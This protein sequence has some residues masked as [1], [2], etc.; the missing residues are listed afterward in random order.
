MQSQISSDYALNKVIINPRYP[1]ELFGPD[2]LGNLTEYISEKHPVVMSVLAGACADYTDGIFT[3]TLQNNGIETLSEIGFAKIASRIIKE[4][5][6]T[7]VKVEIKVQSETFEE[8][9]RKKEEKV[10]KI[11]STKT[12]KPK[13]ENPVVFG[14]E[15]KSGNFDKISRINE[16]S[17]NV[18]LQGELFKKDIDARETRN[19]KYIVTFDITDYEGSI[20]CKLFGIEKKDYLRLFERLKKGVNVAVRGEAQY[21]KY[22]RE[23]LVLA[24]DINIVSKKTRCDNAPKKRVELHLHTKMSF[25]DAMS[26]VTEIVKKAQEWGHKAIAIT[27]HG[28]VQAFPDSVK[29]IGDDFKVIFG[30]EAYLIDLGRPIA[31]N[32]NGQS[33][34]DNVVIFDIETT[35]FSPEKDRI[36]E[37]G[38]VKIKNGQIADRFSSFVNP[39]M[40]ISDKISRLTGITDDMVSGAPVIE[41]VLEQFVDFCGDAVLVAHNAAFDMGFI[42]AN[43]K[44]QGMDFSPAYIDTVE[45]ARGAL[46]E[47]ESH[48]LNVV[49]QALGV[50]LQGHHRAVNDAEATAQIYLK[51]AGLAKVKSV[52]ELNEAFEK[53][54]SFKEKKYYHA[55]IIAKNKKGLKNL[56]KIITASHLNYFYK[57]PCVPKS[58]YFRHMEGLIIGTACEQGEL[59]QAILSG[60]SSK[61]LGKIVR[62]YDYLEIQPLGNNEFLIRDGV[63]KSRDELIEI[64]K[65]IIELGDYYKKPVVATCDVHFLDPHDSIYRAILMAG[66]GYSEPDLQPPLYL[67]TTEE[68]LAEFDY[69]PP[70]KAYEI[71]VENTNKIADM[72]EK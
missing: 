69:L 31:F 64:N 63:V 41:T 17:G 34:S 66:Q 48:K 42:K 9:E 13:D 21:D 70:G 61:Q 30:V 47:L 57:K 55:V 52:D 38:A 56:Y 37:I 44:R 3:V 19:G 22:A 39:Q 54:G 58:L 14:K 8:Y 43:A 40:P 49:A 27:D 68:M 23:V 46:P 26:D 10:K 71:V 6:G 12:E 5:F 1:K 32:T 24:K 60:A 51:L 50:S 36:I 20:T 65:K 35:G 67:R 15:I 2:F 28:V 72:C 33:A 7:D 4:Q 29:G 62:M 16:T 45:M 11:E 25:M 18:L 53:E 59:Y